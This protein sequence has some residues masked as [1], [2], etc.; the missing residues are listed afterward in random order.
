[1]QLFAKSAGQNIIVSGETSATPGA[2]HGRLVHGI[3]C[4]R[5]WLLCRVVQC[6]G[7]WCRVVQGWCRGV[8]G[9][10]GDCCPENPAEVS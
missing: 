9:V 10:A 6:A 7:A 5:I 3:W 1:M 8:Q 4:T 2:A